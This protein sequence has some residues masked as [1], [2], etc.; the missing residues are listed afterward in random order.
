MHQVFK[1]ENPVHQDM[2]E[3]AETFWDNWLLISNHAENPDGGTVRYYCYAREDELFDALKKMNK[4]HNTYGDCLI[5]FVG[6][7][8]GYTLGI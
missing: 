5:R 8:R 7:N 4:D 1:V 6:P 2:D 3:I